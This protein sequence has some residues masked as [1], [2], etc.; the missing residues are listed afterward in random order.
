MEHIKPST[1]SIF[2]AILGIHH[3][4]YLCIL[5]TGTFWC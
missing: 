1:M 2:H 4:T 3:H 5:L